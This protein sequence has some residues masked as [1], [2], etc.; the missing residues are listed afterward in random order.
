MTPQDDLDAKVAA[1]STK[2]EE[3]L[4]VGDPH[5]AIEAGAKFYEELCSVRDFTLENRAEL[6][7]DPARL[8]LSLDA[9]VGLITRLLVEVFGGPAELDVGTWM[10]ERYTGG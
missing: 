5:M 3:V 1:L 7:K 6:T 9:V 8:Q 10:N 4:A 2:F